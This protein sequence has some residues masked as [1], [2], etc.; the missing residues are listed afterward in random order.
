MEKDVQEQPAATQKTDKGYEIPVPSKKDVM[1][2]FKKA[3][4]TTKQKP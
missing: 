1:D 2:F 3:A 4:R